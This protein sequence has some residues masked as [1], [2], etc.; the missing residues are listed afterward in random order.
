MCSLKL[1]SELDQACHNHNNMC[2]ENAPKRFK[3]NLPAPCTFHGLL[4][5][6]ENNDWDIS[7]YHFHIMRKA[8]HKVTPNVIINPY[9]ISVVFSGNTPT[10]NPTIFANNL[11]YNRHGYQHDFLPTLFVEH[12]TIASSVKYIP[13]DIFS[14]CYSLKTVIFQGKSS[15]K[16]IGQFAF[17]RCIF[18]QQI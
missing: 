11:S 16:F 13:P 7:D 4:H 5:K 12:V 2:D 8:N 6:L 14:K 3:T 10:I 18:L 15:L 1:A 9:P 17:S